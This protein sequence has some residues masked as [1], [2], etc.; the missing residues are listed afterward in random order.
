MKCSYAVVDGVGRDVFKDPIT[1]K[2]KK[3]KKGRIKLI[4][5]NGENITILSSEDENFDS[6]FNL[7]TPVYRLDP[8]VSSVPFVAVQKWNDIQER[9]DSY[10]FG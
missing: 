5:A 1:D 7:L 8:S 4:S 2:G 10:I 9:V 6:H 3:S